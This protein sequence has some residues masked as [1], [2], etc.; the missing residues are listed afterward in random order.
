MSIDLILLELLIGAML[1]G[2]IGAYKKRIFDRVVLL[3]TVPAAFIASV[4]FVKSSRFGGIITT[5]MD[6]FGLTGPDNMS[7]TFFG[8]M[9]DLGVAFIA[10][11]FVT[12]LFWVLLFV[13]RITVGILLFLIH[14]ISGCRGG[15]KKAKRAWREAKKA[16][17]NPKK[18]EAK[19]SL[20]HRYKKPLW[21]KF[22]SG[23]I[24]ALSG[25]L[26][27]MLSML[28]LMYVNNF[29]EPAVNTALE[30]ENKDT[31]VNELAS[32]VDEK[33]M[34]LSDKTAFGKIQKFTGMKAL[35]NKALTYLTDVKVEFDS[36]TTVEFNIIDVVSAV[37]T[38]AVSAASIYERSCDAT[39]TFKDFG[40]I[41]TIL[42]KL[43]DNDALMNLCVTVYGEF[44][45][46]LIED[47]EYAY[48]IE[49]A[50]ALK[51]DL[52]A[53]AGIVELLST[54][55]AH[56][57]LESE[58][59]LT[60]ILAYL[61]N[62]ESSKKFVGILAQSKVY[63]T[64]FPV[65]ME[66]AL[67]LICDQLALPEDKTADYQGFVSDMLAACND[68]IGGHSE[69]RVEAFIKYCAENDVLISDY[70][71]NQDT[72]SERDLDYYSYLNFMEKLEGIEKA[73][74]DRGID[75][76]AKATFYL[77]KD[78]KT[79]YVYQKLL[80]KW[81]LRTDEE[82][83]L[84][85]H[86]AQ[87]LAAQM[88][89]GFSDESLKATAQALA[90]SVNADDLTV[91]ANTLLM[92]A[93][94]CDESA[95]NPLDTVYRNDI[96]DSLNKDAAFTKEHNDS[97]AGVLATMAT[98]YTAL[99]EEA[100]EASIDTVIENFGLVGR[101]LDGM[102][103]MESTTAIPDMMIKALQKNKNY[104]MIF[105]TQT[106]KDLLKEVE[107]GNETYEGLFNQ[108]IPIY[109]SIKDAVKM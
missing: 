48:K 1:L 20:R 106:A 32:V 35:T 109:L 45:D 23:V 103:M 100:D 29:V 102:K 98:L 92:F 18:E 38:E 55:L 61:E 4:I 27:V 90:L 88:G 70:T 72:P 26:I 101:M 67:E 43:A 42:T 22:T 86:A 78:G 76:G 12:V 96:V 17:L 85:S 50:E 82:L 25:F 34:P 37:A 51:K 68:P 41:A 8:S 65:L 49:S 15:E 39:G 74:A 21:H 66:Y 53:A 99:T 36:E 30:E 7:D 89:S 69:E 73:F 2:F 47:S 33:F 60:E 84:G 75:D 46:E 9:I 108:L 63:E 28:P 77:A 81:V 13:L 62:E 10:P 83:R 54:D 64:Y 24:G 91:R 44:G 14:T 56:V 95:F 80:N 57:S 93:A 3:L 59:M 105:A 71:P 58:D 97:F 104:G 5:L 107:L 87:L 19:K 52:S 16:G 6:T 11:I 31:Y 79:I 40:P 94:I